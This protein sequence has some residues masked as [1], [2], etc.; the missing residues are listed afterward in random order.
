MYS[1]ASYKSKRSAVYSCGK[2]NACPC[3]GRSGT[4]STRSSVR[5]PLLDVPTNL[6]LPS[7]RA[8]ST[9]QAV[10]AIYRHLKLPPPDI[11][12]LSGVA[13]TQPKPYYRHQNISYRRTL[14]PEPSHDST[15]S[16]SEEEVFLN[17]TDHYITFMVGIQ[18]SKD[19]K[20]GVSPILPN[21]YTKKN[22]L[23]LLKDPETCIKQPAVKRTLSHRTNQ[24]TRR[25]I[26]S[27]PSGRYLKII[28][29]TVGS[30]FKWEHL[31]PM[32]RKKLYIQSD[33]YKCHTQ[34][35][36]LSIFILK[37]FALRNFLR[38]GWRCYWN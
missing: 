30:F 16:D 31:W 1:N 8:K 38:C 25:S 36:F 18:A 12:P 24:G 15:D 3:S 17:G 28:I 10:E 6:R 9:S 22:T 13:V 19:E 7:R 29:P 26:T 21:A 20:V 37:H 27:T 23:V 14:T 11:R 33:S 32:C 4:F 35:F 34:H 5:A 2:E